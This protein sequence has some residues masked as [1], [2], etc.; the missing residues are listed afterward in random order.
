MARQVT[1]LDDPKRLGVLRSCEIFDTQP[2][3]VFDRL[4]QLAAH[5][6]G[7]PYAAITVVDGTGPFYK[8]TVGFTD[9]GSPRPAVGYTAR[10]PF[11]LR[12]CHDLLEWGSCDDDAAGSD[13]KAGRETTHGR[14]HSRRNWSRSRP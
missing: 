1:A 8:A 2:E 3:P 6:C 9:D 14:T 10:R 4:A 11:C 7:T 5:I 12:S 13:P